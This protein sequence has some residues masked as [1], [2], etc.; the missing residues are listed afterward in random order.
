MTSATVVLLT[1]DDL[2]IVNVILVLIAVGNLIK[3]QLKANSAEMLP[4]A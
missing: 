2:K 4:P 1:E 3:R